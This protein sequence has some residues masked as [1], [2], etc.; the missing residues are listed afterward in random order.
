[1]P[2]LKFQPS[3]VFYLTW[4]GLNGPKHVAQF[5]IF[6]T[7]ICC[8]YWL[9]KLLYY[10]KTQR[11]GSYKINRAFLLTYSAFVDSIVAY[12]ET[13]FYVKHNPF[14]RIICMYLF[15]AATTCNGIT[16]RETSLF[17][18]VRPYNWRQDVG[19]LD[20]LHTKIK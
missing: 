15:T 10:C 12:L 18:V 9:N 3:Y 13:L 5:L 1:M 14:V 16:Q 20:K 8:V 4:W 6:I 2:L 19:C 7:N 17:T 11:D